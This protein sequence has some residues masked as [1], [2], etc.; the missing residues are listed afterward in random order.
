[1]QGDLNKANQTNRKTQKFGL[2]KEADKPVSFNLKSQLSKKIKIKKTLL[3]AE[4]I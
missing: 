4:L 1:M 3:T 2:K